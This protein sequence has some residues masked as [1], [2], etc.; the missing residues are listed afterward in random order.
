MTR[1]SPIRLRL[2]AACLLTLTLAPVVRAE[3][4][5]PISPVRF[6]NVSD[7]PELVDNRQPEVG[8]DGQGLWIAVFSSRT[9]V[10]NVSSDEDILFSR[11]LDSGEHWSA[12]AP[13]SPDSAN[14]NRTERLPTIATDRQGH[15]VAVWES[16]TA[17]SDQ[18]IL[19]SRSI[20]N[21]A[22]WSSA[23]ALNTNAGT[24]TGDDGGPVIACDGQGIWIAAWHSKESVAGSGWDG[25]ILF[26]R[27]ADN[28][29]TWTSPLP[30]NS[31]AT[32]DGA[33]SDTFPRLA[34]DGLGRW[35]AVWMVE[36]SIGA[37]PDIL[38]ARSIDNGISWSTP[39]F[40]N[41]NGTTAAEDYTPTIATDRL[42]HWV[43]AWDAV[44]AGGSVEDILVTRS[45]DNGVNWSQ[46]GPLNTNAGDPNEDDFYVDLTADGD[47]NWVAVWEVDHISGSEHDYDLFVARSID[48]GATWSSPSF[49]NSN[50]ATD[51]NE[52]RQ[53]RIATDGR[54]EWVVVWNANELDQNGD[55]EVFAAHLGLPDCNQNLIGDPLETAAGISP[56]INNNSRPDVCDALGLPPAGGGCGGG[57]CGAGTAAFGPAMLI[58]A[59]ILR[60]STRQRRKE[61]SH[62]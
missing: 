38:F 14:D 40:I 10:N 48:N 50:S 3:L 29:A 36:A 52:D 28:G 25:D 32:T 60:R 39:A 21:G 27:S 12:P 1:F 46:V 35:V 18:D 11:S 17:G 20:D 15:W 57:I 8:T 30:L 56:D 34:T 26:A 59:T 49:L 53:A 45:L 31:N 44:P 33:A 58:G 19:T 7:G 41:P 24:D 16:R 9:I 51:S 37:A 5:V 6:V 47:G 54:G 13:V 23:I 22:N 42:G 4:G 43:V 55:Q 62:A 61:K 2:V